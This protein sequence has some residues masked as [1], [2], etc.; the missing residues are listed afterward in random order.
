MYTCN[1][2]EIYSSQIF[3]RAAL[4]HGD[5]PLCRLA[6]TKV[7]AS[8]VKIEWNEQLEFDIPIFEMPRSTKLCIVIYQKKQHGKKSKDVMRFNVAFVL[9][10]HVHE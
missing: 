8:P 5:Q 6:C 1:S 10:V 2:S 9:H 3:V 4:Y 7:G